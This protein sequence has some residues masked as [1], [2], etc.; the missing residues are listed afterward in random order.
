MP[1]RLVRKDTVLAEEVYADPEAKPFVDFVY[2][3][4]HLWSQRHP[5]RANELLVDDFI[6]TGMSKNPIKGKENIARL[7]YS[8]HDSVEDFHFTILTVMH[9]GDLNKGTIIYEWLASGK[10]M[11]A[12]GDFKHNIVFDSTQANL[13]GT[14]VLQIEGNKAKSSAVF[15][16]MTR[17]HPKILDAMATIHH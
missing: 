12:F 4:S 6:S 1:K 14:S 15:I 7:F 16:D 5:E 17:T 10:S 3:Y 2:N 8:V 9:Q 11:K 13:Y